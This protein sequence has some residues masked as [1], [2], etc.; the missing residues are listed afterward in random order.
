MI[1]GSTLMTLALLPLRHCSSHQELWGCDSL[2]A[3]ARRLK[4]LSS[5]SAGCLLSSAKSVAGRVND[6]TISRGHKWSALWAAGKIKLVWKHVLMVRVFRFSCAYYCKCVFHLFGQNSLA[7]IVFHA[8]TPKGI[9]RQ[10]TFSL[11][12][13]PYVVA[14]APFYIAAKGQISFLLPYVHFDRKVS[15]WFVTISPKLGDGGVCW[16]LAATRAHMEVCVLA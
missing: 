5:S 11:A 15:K 12:S 10:F 13:P 8:H 7:A 4:L 6:G 2:N 16:Q 14:A 3:V 9:K 1:G